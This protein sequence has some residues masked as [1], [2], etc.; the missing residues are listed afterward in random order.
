MEIPT[1]S[2]VSAAGIQPHKSGVNYQ[3]G[4]AAEQSDGRD[5]DGIVPVLSMGEGKFVVTAT[6][7]T[8]KKNMGSLTMFAVC[9]NVC[10]CWAGTASSLQI[11]LLQGGPAS[12]LY[13]M[14]V[15]STVY[16][17]VAWSMAELASVYPTAGGQ[18]HF[19]SILAP[20]R[21]N[22]VISYTCGLLTVFSWIAIAAAVTMIPA[23][24]ILALASF[25]HPH[26][27]PKPWHYF[28]LFEAIVIII[29]AYNTFLL[30]NLPRTHDVGFAWSISMFI[31][32]TIV[33]FARSSPKADSSFVWA[34]FINASGWPDGLCFLGS[35]LTTC[36]IYGGLDAALHLAEETPNPRTAVP[37]AAVNAVLIGFATAFIF[38]ITLLY[39]ISDFD[40]V[41]SIQ[42]YL[43]FEL[44]RQGMRS[45]SGAVAT[46]VFSMGLVFFVLN[47]VMQTSSRLTWAFAKDNALVFSG[48]LG[49]IHPGL[50]IPLNSLLLNTALVAVCGCIFLASS[51]AFNAFLGSLVVLQQFSFMIPTALLLFR[52][53][54]SKFLPA[55][56]K[57]A[58]PDRLGWCANIWLVGMSILL[59]VV[60]M[61]PPF[62]PV[63]TTNMNYTVVILGIAAVLGVANWFLHAR[64]QY[65]GPRIVLEN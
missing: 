53:R 45:D 54:S 9:F 47:A 11:A 24:Q 36:F 1:K 49:K 5:I 4:P 7:N 23:T 63:T 20:R 35:L 48:A 55:D 38:T 51:T 27:L 8:M 37:K 2:P 56:R 52:R 34:S 22:A 42:G 64:K 14:I 18:Y 30:K 57:Y 19:A 62:R 50:D 26:F 31:A 29:L 59:A 44:Y 61:L 28:V 40:A 21:L 65:Q 58:L 12:L 6:G 60:F 13:G 3:H 10:N 15:S 17:A 32:L 33:I 43:P 25:Y 16:L 41:I 46:M 39:S